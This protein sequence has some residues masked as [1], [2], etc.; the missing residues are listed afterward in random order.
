VACFPD[1]FEIPSHPH[2]QYK[3][4]IKLGSTGR[5][6]VFTGRSPSGMS[7]RMN[8]CIGYLNNFYIFSPRLPAYCPRVDYNEIQELSQKCV[9]IARRIGGCVEPDL[10]D[11]SLDEECREYMEERFGYSQCVSNN[12]T[13]YDFFRNEWWV[14]L[15]QP[16]EIWTNDRDTLILRD[17]NGLVVGAYQY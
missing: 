6:T 7:F 13:Y 9:D 10:S 17:N 14:Y 8:N 15:D 5:V 2:F 3:S 16:F 11:P 4:D 1:I 12:N